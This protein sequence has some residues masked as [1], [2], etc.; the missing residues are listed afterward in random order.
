MA[1]V[2]FY[3]DT[4]A[5]LQLQRS[6]PMPVRS[7]QLGALHAVGAHF[8]RYDGPAIVAL[9]TGVGKTVVGAAV[10]Y[11]L[12]T[13][14]RVLYVVPSRVLRR[15]TAALLASQQQ[16][17]DV[18]ML[19]MTGPNPVVREVEGVPQSWDELAGA[20]VVVGLP[21]SLH[22]LLQT[23]P[24]P[25]D[26]FGA[27]I[28]DEAHHAAAPTWDS[29][30]SAFDARVVLLTAT[31]YRRDLREL[32]GQVVYDY[33]LSRAISD[34]AYEAVE[35]IGVET[36]GLSEIAA[37]E[38]I[39]RRAIEVLRGP[40]HAGTD[41]RLL[42]RAKTKDRVSELAV[43]YGTLGLNI[44]IVHGD[45]HPRTVEARLN[46]LR[47]GAADGVA[48]VGVLGE[49]FD[50]PELKVGA[51]Q[52][53]TTYDTLNRPTHRRE[54]SP[55]GP[56]LAEWHYDAPGEAGLLD[57]TVRHDPTGDWIVDTDGY[58][59]RG[60][61]TGRTWTVP[62][63]VAALAGDY[64]VS[65]GYDLADH[66]TSVTYPAVGGLPEEIVTTTYN[67]VG[68][69][70]AMTGADQYIW[71]A[72]YDDRARPSWFIS[73]PSTT[74]FSRVWQY[75]SDQRLSRMQAGGGSTVLQDHQL[76]YDP[77]GNIT[78]RNSYLDGSAWRECFGYDQR[79]RLAA[80][81]TTT[82]A[83]ATGTPNTGTNPY[84]HTYTYSVDGNLEQRTEGGTVIGY[85][86]PPPGSDQPHS[87]TVV[88]GDTYSWDANGH[89]AER[90]L[91]G[92][93]DSLTWGPERNLEAVDGPSGSS[94]YVYDAAGDR[95]LRTAPE[96]VTLF[97]EG[98][99]VT[100]PADGSGIAAVRTY[101]L[102]GALIATRDVA[103]V[104][105]IAADNQ[106]SVELAVASGSASATS[107]RTYLPYGGVR[108]GDQFDSDRAWISQVEDEATGLQYLNAR[109]YDP[110]IGRF[111]EPDPL[112]DVARPQSI[113]PY[114]Y[115]LN[116]PSTHSDPTGLAVPV[117]NHSPSLVVWDAR[118]NGGQGGFGGNL[119]SPSVR[120]EV[121]IGGLVSPSLLSDMLP[122]RH[123]GLA[124]AATDVP[125]GYREYGPDKIKLTPTEGEIDV[126]V[127]LR[128]FGTYINCAVHAVNGFLTPGT[129]NDSSENAR[130]HMTLA[131]KLTIALNGDVE[132]A[133][134]LLD[135][136]E[137]IVQGELVADSMNDARMMDLINN[138]LG[139]QIGL[140][141]LEYERSVGESM[142]QCMCE[143]GMALAGI[144]PASSAEYI[145]TATSS[146][147]ERQGAVWLVE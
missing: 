6:G 26:L 43:L 132:A 73:G 72:L 34:G 111:T 58:D 49:G 139:V 24:P 93:T 31:P 89:L 100:V 33:P 76:A 127:G 97:I 38:A 30:L 112:F 121:G 59:T 53:H 95:Q 10:P 46:D 51:Y 75:N 55:A 133:R 131:A 118:Y 78:E 91:S 108:S 82:G 42:V 96:G 36:I 39:A 109:F 140:D 9:P 21:Q 115:G 68:I 7:A 92:D 63:S 44:V 18:G 5:S 129:P 137:M 15:Q 80:A 110:N 22:P 35:F 54:G 124:G 128:S 19:P 120:E 17:R 62:T 122:D 88:G 81:F 130:T 119:S 8:T 67:T 125:G 144:E 83:C 52:L 57:Q 126:C 135:A 116:N 114:V 103:G 28:A 20:D 145:Y 65:Y 79:N 3:D 107:V 85:T 99:E 87:P 69:P 84:D 70:E 64:T 147:I 37:D 66:P 113:N 11:L 138:E 86:Y 74:P 102:G 27:V 47:Q 45:L 141:Y 32:P 123:Q 106:G 2:H 4:D 40:L 61:P 142:A 117:S 71:A 13:A 12:D 60:R 25:R 56:V 146:I 136:H 98:H 50:C 1:Q 77:I 134:E 143:A 105:Y 94:S 48:F 14:G 41:S 104:D 16:L 101:T 23:E 29:L 90:T